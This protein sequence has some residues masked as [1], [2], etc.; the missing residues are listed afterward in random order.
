MIMTTDVASVYTDRVNGEG[1]VI[2][3]NWI[4]DTMTSIDGRGVY[5]DNTSGGY[6]I[7]H[8]VFWKMVNECVSFPVNSF[9]DTSSVT[10]TAN[11]NYL[12]NNTFYDCGIDIYFYQPSGA[13]MWTQKIYNNIFAD[14][15]ELRSGAGCFK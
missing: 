7:H 14:A 15:T 4:H 13:D 5:L 9:V 10:Y 8:N 1:T 2:A 12:F 11:D 6:V 3:Y